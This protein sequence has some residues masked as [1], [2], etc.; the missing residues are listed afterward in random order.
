[1]R[2]LVIGVIRIVKWL[3]VGRVRRGR[4]LGVS[5]WGIGVAFEGHYY[6]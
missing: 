6:L 2:V 1:M 4:V 3:G 5:L